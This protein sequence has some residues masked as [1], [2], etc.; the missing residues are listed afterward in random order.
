MVAA[1]YRDYVS[2]NLD[3]F[4]AQ[5]ET[6]GA[7]QSEGVFTMAVER[8]RWKMSAFTL[9]DPGLFPVHLLASAVAL[10]ASEFAVHRPSSGGVDIFSFDGQ[11]YDPHELQLLSEPMLGPH[12]P[13]AIRE[14]G[15][16][17]SAAG[18]LGEARLLSQ[19]GERT[20][21]L[22]VDQ[23]GVL[24]KEGPSTGELGQ[25]LV[26]VYQA[27]QPSLEPLKLR[28]SHAPLE[29]LI[30]GRRHH[31]DLDFGFT[32]HMLYGLLNRKGRRELA[33]SED[34]GSR[35]SVMNL[36]VEEKG[37]RSL[38]VALT[39]PGYAQRRKWRY[40]MNGVEF[41]GPGLKTD[42]PFTCGAVEAGD[43]RRDLSQSGI[44]QDQAFVE[45]QGELAQAEEELIQE[46]CAFSGQDMSRNHQVLFIN[47]LLERYQGQEIPAR[48]AA[49]L[50]EKL[51]PEKIDEVLMRVG[52]EAAASNNW[53]PYRE[54]RRELRE[55]ADA[56]YANRLVPETLAS[57]QKEVLLGEAAGRREA[58]A[59]E[60]IHTLRFVHSDWTVGPLDSDVVHP[61]RNLLLSVPRLT[62]SEL[63][64]RLESCLV[65]WEWKA[66][67]LALIRVLKGKS[68]P[69]ELEEP[70]R[71]D[72]S[73]WELCRRGDFAAVRERL[74]S[75]SRGRERAWTA[76]VTILFRGRMP[77]LESVRWQLRLN[78]QRALDHEYR[79]RRIRRI[80]ERALSES[81]K[82]DLW[83]CFRDLEN[84]YLPLLLARLVYLGE[85]SGK[86][87][88]SI[89]L[90][91]ALLQFSLFNEEIKLS[92]VGDLPSLS[93]ALR[94]LGEG[95]GISP[96]NGSR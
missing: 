46:F 18:A 19:T 20:I 14:L 47:A 89:F 62:T 40:I 36:A 17:L 88:S 32:E 81:G 48:V 82:R 41:E 83:F 76:I 27:G 8:A 35:S 39:W 37:G 30:N 53:A 9:A 43:L 22:R 16:A 64:S 60:L 25:E 74:D 33:V 55:R 78:F 80:L 7:F 15:T 34:I 70:W 73:L 42:F 94:V 10:G 92:T 24:I 85:R 56:H 72:F 71:T 68:V 6:G 44:V 58:E 87:P 66:P 93:G 29:L 86:T 52:R 51:T 45:L 28:C 50:A 96:T 38:V 63:E 31:Q 65:N 13:P 67:L 75:L 3:S 2:S 26:V 54:M 69:E 21:I 5:Q 57:L 4:L 12:V 90:A 11:A 77:L 84:A 91:R 49:Y 61:Y 95:P 23:D 59:E 79:S 1:C